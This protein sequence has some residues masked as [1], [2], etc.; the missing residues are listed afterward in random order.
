M[1]RKAGGGPPFIFGLTKV[2]SAWIC[3]GFGGFLAGEPARKGRLAGGDGTG[4]GQAQGPQI[5]L[6]VAQVGAA[7]L[8]GFAAEGAEGAKGAAKGFRGMCVPAE[9]GGGVAQGD[10]IDE[11]GAP[12]F[13]RLGGLAGLI[14]KVAAKL[15]DGEAVGAPLVEILFADGTAGEFA[16][17]KAAH[18]GLA[19]EPGQQGEAGLV[20]GEAA[21]EF[22]AEGAR[23]AGD[24]GVHK[25]KK[26]S[27][28]RV[29]GQ[30]E[31]FE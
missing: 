18:G 28:P 30:K 29:E 27:T 19:V 2:D 16:G 23:E 1:R 17:E 11:V 7:E 5:A 21:V 4:G 25:F 26:Q 3:W 10:E 24:L 12:F 14:Q 9:H 15:P 8:D 6:L 13:G 22:V 31:R 20:I